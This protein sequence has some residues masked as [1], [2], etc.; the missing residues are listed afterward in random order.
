M[1]NTS[2]AADC[3]AADCAQFALKDDLEVVL[4]SYKFNIF[5]ISDQLTSILK[6]LLIV[7][8]SV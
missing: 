5:S 3:D 1:Y 4:L 2:D 7:F 8:K 6:D